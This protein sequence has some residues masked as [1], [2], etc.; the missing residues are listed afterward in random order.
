MTDL[1]TKQPMNY[2]KNHHTLAKGTDFSKNLFLKNIL[3]PLLPL[4]KNARI[5]EIGPGNGEALSLFINEFGF[6]RVEAIDIAEDVIDACKLVSGATLHLVA[7]ARDF[8]ITRPDHFDLILMYHVLEHF[9][10]DEVVPVLAA[11]RLSLRTGGVMV[12]GVP[13]VS[14]PLIGPEQQ[15]ADFTHRTAFSPSSLIQAHRMAGF[16]NVSVSEV[17]PPKAGFG[18]QVQRLLQ[19][20]LL[21]PM[22]VYMFVMVPHR[23]RVLTHSM[24]CVSR[25]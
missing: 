5:L 14:A 24:I 3:K 19:K 6:E 7:D 25:I 10:Q 2:L 21:V 8:L 20:L 4:C 17:Y 9:S 22:R 11:G 16:A 12:V 13:N 23:N 18:R 1:F 15:Y